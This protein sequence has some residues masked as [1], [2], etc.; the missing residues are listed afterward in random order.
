MLD[1]PAMIAVI[2]L[3]AGDS[4]RM[5]LRKLLLDL[6][7][8]SLLRRAARCATEA[9]TGPVV[10]VLGADA[11]LAR[12]ELDGLPCAAVQDARAT[13]RGMNGSLEV[14]VRALPGGVRGAVVLL[15]DM[16]FV[17]PVTVRALVERHRATGAS[18]VAT[19]YGDAL[20]P[21]VLYDRGLLPELAAGG[22]GDG[23]GREILQRHRARAELVDAPA[24]A[25]VDVDLPADLERVRARLRAGGAH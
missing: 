12:R 24:S 23:R 16:P 18:L 13:S 17:T 15:A 11:G 10:V 14:G 19:R 4:S 25:L 22:D 9:A 1:V 5:G 8:E 2:L 3:A 7:G 21:P 6:E 20:A